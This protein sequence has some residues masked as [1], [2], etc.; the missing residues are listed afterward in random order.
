MSS[1]AAADVAQDAQTVHLERDPDGVWILTPGGDTLFPRHLR[2]L[3]EPLAVSGRFLQAIADLPG[4]TSAVFILTCCSCGDPGCGGMSARSLGMD[5][6]G[7]LLD[8]W[9]TIRGPGA[10]GAVR[11]RPPAGG[12]TAVQELSADF[13][14]DPQ[15]LLVVQDLQD[16]LLLSRPDV[17]RPVPGSAR[18]LEAAQGRVRPNIGGFPAQAFQLETPGEPPRFLSLAEA[19]SA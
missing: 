4:G 17:Y 5:Q 14:V 9:P 8:V 19:L 15:D 12:F 1:T 10:P 3:H 11:L 13:L 6:D 7:L 2:E 16:I 18:L